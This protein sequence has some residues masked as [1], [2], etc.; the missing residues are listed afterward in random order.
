MG[1]RLKVLAL[2]SI[3]AMPCNVHLAP[4][5]HLLVRFPIMFDEENCT[6][7]DTHAMGYFLSFVFHMAEF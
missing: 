2:H 6:F 1:W 4:S 3:S 7:S 5:L